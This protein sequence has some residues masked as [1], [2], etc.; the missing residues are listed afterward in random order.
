MTE[1]EYFLTGPL[2]AAAAAAGTRPQCI[3]IGHRAF[4][5]SQRAAALLRA[6]AEAST[7]AGITERFN[8]FDERGMTVEQAR[9][10]LLE[11]LLPAGL[12]ATSPATVPPRSERKSLFLS[13]TLLS[14]R[15]VGR[16]SPLFCFL[17]S[18]RAAVLAGGTAAALLL[19][20]LV[21]RLRAGVPLIDPVLAV[22]MTVAEALLFCA[23]TA[24][25]FV[26]HELGHAAA[27]CRWGQKPAEIGIGL[28]LIF[29]VLFSNV[30]RAWGLSRGQRLAVNLGGI[31]LQGLATACLVPFQLYGDNPVLALVIVL[32][33]LSL[34]VNLNPFFRFD[35]Y[36]IYADLFDLPN[37]RERSRSWT[38]RLCARWLG[39]ADST[40][41]ASEPLALR[42]YALISP[43]FFAGFTLL[44][45]KHAV[46]FYPAFSGILDSTLHRP[47]GISSFETLLDAAGVWSMLAIYML[48]YVL[49]A[50][51]ILSSALRTVTFLRVAAGKPAAGAQN[52]G[53]V[54]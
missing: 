22:D 9:Q 12:V 11:Q 46:D 43:V 39:R 13:G 51:Y 19:W 7:L 1:D 17:F 34:V 3:F 10:V 32:N 31:Y 23:L 25:T 16:L 53:E 48:G 42:V 33:L 28:Y 26:L 44:A 8:T 24:A 27:T 35:G 50:L 40:R 20:W 36:W 5:G 2:H 15:M 54:A 18:I 14:E 52:I 6:V 45:A 37:L 4:H 21:V 47:A 30:T 49:S 41:R 38:M 29:P